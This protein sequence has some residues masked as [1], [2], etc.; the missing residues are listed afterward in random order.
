MDMKPIKLETGKKDG[1]YYVDG[2]FEINSMNNRDTRITNAICEA[3][4]Q[5]AQR[6]FRETKG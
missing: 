3:V 4:R 5:E 2:T 1:K 6:P